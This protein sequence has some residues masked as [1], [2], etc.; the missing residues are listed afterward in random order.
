MGVVASISE[1][2][3]AKL[4]PFRVLGSGRACEY[5]AVNCRLL[6]GLGPHSDT[7]IIN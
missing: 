4:V 7:F 1:D 2:P 3:K 5:R 6:L